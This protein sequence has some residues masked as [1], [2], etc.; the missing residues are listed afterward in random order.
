MKAFAKGSNSVKR[1]QYT[2]LKINNKNTKQ[3]FQLTTYFSQFAK[4]VF[5]YIQ[6]FF[7]VF[8]H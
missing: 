5:L 1:S 3:K 7:F 6:Q 4:T 2:T 8:F